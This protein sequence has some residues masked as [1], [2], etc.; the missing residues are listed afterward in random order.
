MFT[1]K[2]LLI[3]PQDWSAPIRFSQDD[4]EN[5][6]RG[7]VN[8]DDIIPIIRLEENEY[9]TR[10]QAFAG[11][12]IASANN[13]PQALAKTSAYSLD[14]FVTVMNAVARDLG[15]KNTSLI[16]PTGLSL[17]NLSTAADLTLGGCQVFKEDMIRK[18]AGYS[19]HTYTTSLENEKIF[20]HTL[21][22]L[23]HDLD[24]EIYQAAKTGY[25]N[26]TGYHVTAEIKTPKGK[27]VCVSVLGADTRTRLD[28]VALAMREWVDLMYTQ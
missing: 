13:A 2:T 11:M 28:E 24:Y 1:A 21:Y 18:Y 12:M 5:D 22:G 19:Y 20:S 6:L 8:P 17:D 7:Y 25:L 16:E 3:Y 10:E 23:R 27:S 26:E 14:E 9:I 4:N 15:M